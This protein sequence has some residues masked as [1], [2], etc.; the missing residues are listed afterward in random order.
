VGDLEL[1]FVDS[2]TLGEGPRSSEVLGEVV[3]L[4]DVGQQGGVNGLRREGRYP[5][6]S[7]NSYSPSQRKTH[8]L[9]R[10]PVVGQELLLLTFTEELLLLG[11]LT[12][13]LGLGK[14]GVV[15]GFGNRD[16]GQ[17]NLGGSG[18]DVSLTDSSHRN[19]VESERTRDEEQTGIELLQED[20]SLSSESTG[21]E[22]KD[23]SGGDGSSE[24]GLADS[25]SADLGLGDI[26]GLQRTNARSFSRQAI[27]R[28]RKLTISTY[29]VELSVLLDSSLLFR[30]SVYLLG[31]G[32]SAGL[33]SLVET[34]LG[35]DG[36][37]RVSTDVGSEFRVSGHL[38]VR[39]RE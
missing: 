16:T 6:I 29:G 32:G 3:N 13:R 36:G 1:E 19:T 4:L 35:E 21:Q 24:L 38:R 11:L 7:F 25:L 14:V 15:D 2:V 31:G 5:E 22:D 37:S 39:I 18:N 12:G 10:L 30:S 26:L 33:H 20:D 28:T 27:P 34:S 9:L 8:L 17:I 23:G